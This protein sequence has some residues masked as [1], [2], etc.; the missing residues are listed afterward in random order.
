[1]ALDG[2]GTDIG[3]ENDDGIAEIDLASHRIR[4]DTL[5]EDLQHEIHDIGVSFFDFVKKNH[6]IRAT[7]HLFR[8]LTAFFIADIARR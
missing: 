2:A 7:S 1:M 4:H 5:F 3:G 8:E 6:T